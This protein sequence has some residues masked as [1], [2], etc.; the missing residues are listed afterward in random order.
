MT[1]EET[2]TIVLDTLRPAPDAVVWDIGAGTG[3]VSIACS[4]LCPYGEV[5][6]IERLPEA[7]ELLNAN[8]KKFHA[9]NLF[10]H[11]GDAEISLD[12]LPRPTHVFVGGSGGK[13]PQILERVKNL[14]TAGGEI[15]TA[16]SG[17]TL[18]TI[19]TAYEILSGD[20]FGGLNVTQFS[21]S[22]GKIA[23]GSMILAAQNPVTLLSARAGKSEDNERESAC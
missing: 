20:G 10:I 23:G 9:Y 6:A 1:R 22:R 14:G 11:E 8:R 7:V 5:H 13:L 4:R 15:F 17:V 12:S 3:S 16:V 19:A 21:V 2:R 18:K